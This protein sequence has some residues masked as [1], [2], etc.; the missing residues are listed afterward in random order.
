MATQK[1]LSNRLRSGVQRMLSTALHATMTDD[2][3]FVFPQAHRVYTPWYEKSFL[4]RVE[5]AASRTLL[6]P[7]RLWMLARMVEQCGFLT[8]A[9]AE[10]GSYKGG[11]ARLI[12][13]VLRDAG[14]G[15]ELHVFDTFEGMPE[16]AEVSRDSHSKGDFGDTGLE[17]VRKLLAP[18]PFV[19][20]HPGFIPTTFE[21]LEETTFS[22][23][24]V[25]VDIYSTTHDCL[26]F[27]YPR[28]TRGGICLFDDYGFRIY[29]RAEKQAVDEF[30][31]DK[32]EKPFVLP[33]G[34]A[35]VIKL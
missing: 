34:Q 12:A 21:G 13:E 8:G 15:T 4:Q 5:I 30:F 11:S 23:V 24:H 3:T 35:F 22:F 2:Y 14:R 20:I 29:A 7:D 17:A 10:C 27:F 9:M 33:N 26:R 18:F 1:G 31:A 25:D 19:K 16:T 32:P 28:L 6:S